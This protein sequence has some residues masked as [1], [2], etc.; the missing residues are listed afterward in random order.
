MVGR[1]G[2]AEG[3]KALSRTKDRAFES[4]VSAPAGAWCSALDAECAE[5]AGKIA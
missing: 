4:G 3:S 5:V 2:V 1:R